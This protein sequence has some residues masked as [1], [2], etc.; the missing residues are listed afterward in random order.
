MP[1]EKITY[2]YEDT[3]PKLP[4][5]SLASTSEQILDSIKPLISEDDYNRLVNESMN[6]L[7]SN[8]INLLQNY[9]IKSSDN[10]DCYL[11]AE[12]ISTTT[13]GIYG[14]LRG[15]TLP[16]NPFFI[17][18]DDPLAKTAMP[19]SQ[20]FR[21]SVLVTSTLRLILSLRF[22]VLKP[23]VSPKNGS[24]LSMNTYKNLFGTSRVP[25]DSPDSATGENS[26]N[27]SVG[28]TIKRAPSFND[29]RHIVVIAKSQFYKLEVLSEDNQIWFSKSELKNVLLEILKD[30][31]NNDLIYTTR[32][33]I[34]S[35]TTESKT[36][37]RYSRK[38]LELTNPESLTEIDN[39]LFVL[40][41]DHESPKSEK[42]KVELVGH[43]SSRINSN[44][45]QIGSCISRWYDKLQI[46]VTKNSVAGVIWESTSM[47]G[48][49]V[50]RF[51]GDVYT[52]SVLRLAREING[53]N[54]TLWPNTNTVPINDKIKK[55]FFE[56]LIFH[57]NPEIITG[58]HLAETRLADLINQHEYVV[59]K[60]DK[61]GFNLFDN[62][63][64]VNSDSFI[65]LAI[66]I[67]YYALYG[68]LPS[69]SE[70]ITT[71][72][73]KNSRT[74]TICI[75]SDSILRCCQSFITNTTYQTKWNLIMESL[76]EHKSKIRNAM[77]GKGFERHLSA[78]RS[79]Y[80]QRN[81]LNK[82]YKDLPDI[83]SSPNDFPPL[84]FDP[85]LDHLYR[86]ELLSANCGNP[87]LDMFGLTPSIPQ[88]FGIGYI[89]KDDHITF[90]C[91]SQWRQTGR[92]LETLENVM[93]EMKNCWK[94]NVINSNH[95]TTILYH[96]S[97]VQNSPIQQQQQA[98]ND[99]SK[100]FKQNQNGDINQLIDSIPME[101]VESNFSYDDNSTSKNKN[102]NNNNGS[103]SGKLSTYKNKTDKIDKQSQVRTSNI[104]GG[105]DYFDVIDLELRSG[106]MTRDQSNS[107]SVV[108]TR[109]NSNM[110]LAK[111]A[112][113][114]QINNSNGNLNDQMEV[115][116]ESQS[117]SQSQSQS[118]P[119]SPT[120]LNVNGI[121][122]VGNIT[123]SKNNPDV[124][125]KLIVQDDV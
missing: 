122:N 59:S 97:R 86:I 8:S 38:L 79:A 25:F 90:V 41:L 27:N 100:F 68:K 114:N 13:P 18:E 42:E 64:K 28:I 113:S 55:P 87:A 101:M 98:S 49:S 35:L 65:Q 4:V 73:F 60:I 7:N 1:V 57:L 2:A 92:F 85:L 5:P 69:S 51:V 72:K 24:K 76:C 37:W 11:D 20:A 103:G 120:Q 96:Y 46:V 9:L 52:D 62:K 50:L 94:L 53:L 116:P 22:E 88:G 93:Q 39:A 78:L 81:V 19:P 125:R 31:E 44:G 102:N 83:S 84:I 34:G 15:N 109:N 16:R 67:T 29:S 32:H 119:H 61:F 21:A 58:L 70:P 14:E 63:M 89:V 117:K 108:V 99:K 30:S 118:Q 106:V 43:G 17:L 124:G 66:Q 111:V 77:N 36:K 23:D 47:D 95:D 104:L 3:L 12:G 107:N 56:K 74:E 45:I 26:D 80:L 112:L 10:S 121:N 75:Q 91:S 123:S 105:Y 54:Y 6:F 33:A 115:E 110:N 71:R 82:M 48:T 40:V